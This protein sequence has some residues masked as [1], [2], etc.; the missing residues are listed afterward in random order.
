MINAVF[1]SV[2]RTDYSFLQPCCSFSEAS[3]GNAYEESRGIIQGKVKA[4]VAQG[5]ASSSAAILPN[6]QDCSTKAPPF[7]LLSCA[8]ASLLRLIEQLLLGCL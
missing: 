6:Q 2:R 5:L 7:H 4:K 1:D 8:N 3:W